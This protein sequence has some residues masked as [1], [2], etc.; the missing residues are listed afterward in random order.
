MFESF[1]GEFRSCAILANLLA[2]IEPSSRSISSIGHCHRF[3][4]FLTRA[5][6][7]TSP[8]CNFQFAFDNALH[9]PSVLRQTFPASFPRVTFFPCLGS[10]SPFVGHSLPAC[11]EQGKHANLGTPERNEDVV[12]RSDKSRRNDHARDF[13]RFL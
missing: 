10:R 11:R 1:R 12:G 2:K 5:C 7:H 4:L 3:S 13:S 9:L 8:R 6:A